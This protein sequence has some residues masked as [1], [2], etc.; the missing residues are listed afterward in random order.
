[1]TILYVALGAVF[2]IALWVM[3]VFNGVVRLRN[4]LLEGWSGID[5]QL[6]RRHDLIP[7]L[8]DC[9]RAYSAHERTVLE[10]VTK[11][12]AESAATRGVKERETSEN[13][14]SQGLRALFAVAEDYPDLKADQSFLELQ[15]QLV[16]VEDQI[17]LARRYY[18]GTV[19]NYNIRVESFPSN[20]VARAF[21]FG[22]AE[23]F[24][25]ETATERE[26]PQ[27]EV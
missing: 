8:V 20:A 16:E 4:L 24:E 22:S 15:K 3:T 2:I 13:A 26:V 11:A 1:M 19:R 17:Q 7:N 6:R 5:V 21:R 18:N 12:R 10:D 14:L 25:L 27:V 23:F 9:V